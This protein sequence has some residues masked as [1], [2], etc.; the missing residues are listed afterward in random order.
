[1]TV[2]V[3]TVYIHGRTKTSFLCGFEMNREE[4]PFF[5]STKHCEII[6]EE[7]VGRGFM[8]AR[9]AVPDWL[10]AQTPLSN[11]DPEDDEDH[12]SVVD[13]EDEAWMRGER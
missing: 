1:M 9:I 7:N 13:E 6:E 12:F 3:F 11:T 4:K 10:V 8:K 5:L 2:P